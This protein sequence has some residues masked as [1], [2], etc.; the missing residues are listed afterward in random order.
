MKEHTMNIDID[1]PR[2]EA[3]M[4]ALERRIRIV[5]Q[6]LRK[7]WTEP[8]AAAQAELLDLAAEA[9]ALYTLRA[10]ARGRL[11]RTE[12]PRALRDSNDALGVPLKWDAKEHN[13]KLAERVAQRYP[14]ST[15]QP[16]GLGIHDGPRHYT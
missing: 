3:D 12:P 8:M 13:R 15:D 11:H 10:W 7:P 2:L 6:P 5:K 16:A 1:I 9:T 14:P 4:R